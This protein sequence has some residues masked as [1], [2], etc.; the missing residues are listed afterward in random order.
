V[1]TN[2]NRN[3]GKTKGQQWLR[4]SDV[5]TLLGVSANTV[6]RWTDDGRVR[7]QRSP[8]G[9]RRYLRSDV[10]ALPGMQTTTEASALPQPLRDCAPS[11]TP[12]PTSTSC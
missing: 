5:A 6:R 10:L 4:V 9:H 2:G 12:V 1:R 3:T 11:P 7:C 8:G